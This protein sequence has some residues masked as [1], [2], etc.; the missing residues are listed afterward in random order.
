MESLFRDPDGRS[1]NLST[2]AKLAGA[3]GLMRDDGREANRKEKAIHAA[4]NP[5]WLHDAVLYVDLQ[6]LH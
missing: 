5:H 6:V 2:M 1:T 4:R 3:V